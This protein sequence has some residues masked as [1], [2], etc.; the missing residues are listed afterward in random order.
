LE[1]LA[2][3]WDRLLLLLGLLCCS[4]FFSASE[5]ALFSLRRLDR[6]ELER[7]GGPGAAAALALLADPRGLLA[8]VLFGNLVVNILFFATST[9]LGFE[10]AR[11]GRPAAAAICGAAALAAVIA[12]GEIAPKLTALSS[13][14]RFARILAL[15]LQSFYGL[16]AP[17]R[18]VLTALMRRFEGRTAAAPHLAAQE[19]S[20]LVE[21]AGSEGAIG[22]QERRLVQEAVDLAELRASHVMI[23]RVDMVAC[24]ASWPASRLVLLAADTSH[25]RFPVYRGTLDEIVGIADVFDALQSP[26]RPLGELARPAKFIPEQKKVT[27]LL[28]EF[29]AEDREIAIVS[30]EFGGT[31]GLVTLEDMVEEVVGDIRE[32]HEMHRPAAVQRLGPQRYLLAGDLSAEPWAEAIDIDPDDL[33]VDRLGGLVAALL[34]HIPRE[35]DTVKRGDLSFTVQKMRRRRVTEVL[36][37]LASAEAADDI[38]ELDNLGGPTRGTNAPDGAGSPP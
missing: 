24:E 33:G 37:E 38:D 18:A 21:L 7:R 12:F 25:G 35:G 16:I 32:P 28:A 17:A 30:D 4:F 29:Q 6:D 31:A 3:H 15:P 36:L 23:P 20:D 13:P 8:S 26:G 10:L 14:Q 27:A 11:T 34:G 22:E 2:A 9:V 1:I 5:A 19:L